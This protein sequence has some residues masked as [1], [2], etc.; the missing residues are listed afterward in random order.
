M[1]VFEQFWGRECSVG[2]ASLYGLDFRGSNPSG[3]GFFLSSP[4]RSWRPL[5]FLYNGYR[6]IPG[7]KRPGLGVD[8]PPPSI[9]EKKK[10]AET[11][12]ISAPPLGLHCLF[13]G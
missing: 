1:K 6:V 5:S 12:S 9:T 10:L 2:L 13:E 11:Y 4:D 3:G 7:A 8:H